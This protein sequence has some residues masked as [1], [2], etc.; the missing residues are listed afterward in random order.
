[1]SRELFYLGIL[2]I[3]F[4]PLLIEA[5]NPCAWIFSGKIAHT[6][7]TRC[8][9]YFSCTFFIGSL[10]NCGTHE[11]FDSDLR[12][13]IPGDPSACFS[14]TSQFPTTTENIQTTTELNLAEICDE[15]FFSARPHP[16][17]KTLFIGCI[18]GDGIIM[19]CLYGEIFDSNLLKCVLVPDIC[20]VPIDICANTRLE[21]A[22]NPCH[23]HRFFV[24]YLGAI[25]EERDCGIGLIF[26]EL[27][28]E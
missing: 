8:N 26:D 2:L 10:R 7:P 5:Q 18:R 13:C 12:S 28:N 16:V 17:S 25:K 4:N 21:I 1:M 6:D 20:E 19:T 15:V 22:A 11:I 27:R 9:E 24:C 23:C 3:F 14:S